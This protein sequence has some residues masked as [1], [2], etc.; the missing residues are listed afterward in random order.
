LVV[1]ILRLDESSRGVRLQEGNAQPTAGGMSIAVTARGR[2]FKAGAQ[3]PQLDTGDVRR[4]VQI[5]GDGDPRVDSV[6]HEEAVRDA[7]ERAGRAVAR[8]ALGIPEPA[9]EAP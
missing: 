6:A 4:A 9:D 2:V 1:D 7:A 3:D 8:A 5:S